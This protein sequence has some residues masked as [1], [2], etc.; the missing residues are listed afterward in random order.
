MP[1]SVLTGL[2]HVV[3]SALYIYGWVLVARA[4]ASWVSADPRH[5]VVRF[6]GALTDP[7]LRGIRALLPANL[8]AFPVDVAFL[9]LLA[10]VLFARHAV[11]QALLEHG[12]GLRPLRAGPV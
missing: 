11:A 10:L 2:G 3:H 5:R 12:V 9:V 1:A 7:P 6:L 4:V 8:R